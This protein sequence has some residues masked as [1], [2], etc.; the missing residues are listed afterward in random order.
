VVFCDVGQGDGALI[1]QGNFQL[2]IDTGPAS[3]KILS[4]LGRYMPFWDKTIEAIIIS[5]NDSDH[6]G[7][8][9]SI[10]DYYQVENVYSDGL[11][12]GDVVKYGEIYFDILGPDQD[13]GND[14]DNSVV[15]ILKYKGNKI[16]FLG[17]ITG[18][19]EQKM[20]WRNELEKVNVF[21]VSHHGSAEATSEELLNEVMPIEA[22]I[23]VGI[24]N[25]FGH[26]T[27]EVLD[28]LMR[29]GHKIRRTDVEG[30]IVYLW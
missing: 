3:N 21:K 30:D 10:K 15:G 17:D 23:S 22:V 24:S 1:I 25:K 9:K 27:K 7:G 18:D 4:C 28:R 20:V 16:L 6:N 13:F 12:K 11:A 5:H 8:L 26:P 19:I 2:L 14:N 29:F